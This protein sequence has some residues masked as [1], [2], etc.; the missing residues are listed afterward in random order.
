MSKRTKTPL[1]AVQKWRAEDR[2][3]GIDKYGGIPYT[4][5][6][7]AGRKV[8]RVLA[9]VYRVETYIPYVAPTPIHRN[10]HYVPGRQLEEFFGGW[11]EHAETVID[12]RP[13]TTAEALT[14][15][16]AFRARNSSSTESGVSL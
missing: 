10:V 7:L 6:H 13:M 8:P 11:G 4:Y 16:Q 9:D 1:G 3:T 5:E 2:H 15:L 12:V 14:E